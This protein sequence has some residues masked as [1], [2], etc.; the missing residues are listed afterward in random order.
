AFQ[1]ASARTIAEGC[2]SSATRWAHQAHG[3]MGMTQEYALHH[4]SRRL[5]SWRQEWAA[6]NEW[7]MRVGRMAEAG[8]TDNLFGLITG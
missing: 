7:A 3:A 5:W 4:L 1:I 8:G 6:P 2:A